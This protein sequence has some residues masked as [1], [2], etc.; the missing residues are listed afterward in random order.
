MKRREETVHHGEPGTP[1]HRCGKDAAVTVKIEGTLHVYHGGHG[2]IRCGAL[3]CPDCARALKIVT[4]NH[5][6]APKL[7]YDVATGRPCGLDG[8]PK[9]KPEPTSNDATA[10]KQALEDTV[11][12]LGRVLAVQPLPLDLDAEARAI[13]AA[14]RSTL[15]LA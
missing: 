1:C 3:F 11:D 2:C 13:L 14:G 9:P 15:G 12:V 8:C 5:P 7:L 4:E 6:D 10:F